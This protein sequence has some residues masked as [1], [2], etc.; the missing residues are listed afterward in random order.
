MQSTIF[1]G[2]RYMQTVDLHDSAM[3]PSYPIPTATAVAFVEWI[4]G[5]AVLPY[6][7]AGER[8]VGTRIAFENDAAAPIGPIE[9]HVELIEIEGRKLRFKIIAHDAEKV[10]GR[11]FNERLIVDGQT[12]ARRHRRQSAAADHYSAACI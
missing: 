5:E 11:G 4:C 6:L 8:S 3:T 9:A 2:M 12:E 1:T 7:D 10:I